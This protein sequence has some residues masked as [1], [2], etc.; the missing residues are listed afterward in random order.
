MTGVG[1][2]TAFSP[3]WLSVHPPHAFPLSVEHPRVT[4]DPALHLG[5]VPSDRA[6]ETR[7]VMDGEHPVGPPPQ[8]LSA[9]HVR[10]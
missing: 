1:G 3:S 2:D 4:A 9:S 6:L 10:R 8:V 7:R 5:L